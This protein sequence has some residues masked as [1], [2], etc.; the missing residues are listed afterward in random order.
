MTDDRRTAI[1]GDQIRDGTVTPA[2]IETEGTE[3]NYKSLIYDSV[4]QKFK[5]MHQLIQGK[6]FK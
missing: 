4:T 3:A 2:E 5:W 6:I 1:D